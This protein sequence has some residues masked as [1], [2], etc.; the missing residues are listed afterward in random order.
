MIPPLDATMPL[1]PPLPARTAAPVGAVGGRSLPSGRRSRGHQAGRSTG[2]SLLSAMS[3]PAADRSRL[4][5]QG[6]AVAGAGWACSALDPRIDRRDVGV[7][8]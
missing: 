1:F 3:R 6:P 8:R 2:R 4:I 5:G 7:A